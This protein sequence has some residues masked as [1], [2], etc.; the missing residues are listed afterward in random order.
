MGS[1]TLL[2]PLNAGGT[3]FKLYVYDQNDNNGSAI[4]AS[5][6]HIEH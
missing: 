3:L 1:I 4:T 5:V 2:T 6:Y